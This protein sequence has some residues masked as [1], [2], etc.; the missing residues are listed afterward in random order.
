MTAKNLK[1]LAAF[2]IATLLLATGGA[3]T[4]ATGPAFPDLIQLPIGFGS[5]GIAVG[6]GHTFYVGSFTAPMVGQ[7]LVGDLRTGTYSEL[8][9]PTG[10]MA[11]G[12]KVDTRSNS[13][14]VAGGVSGLGKIYDARSGAEIAVYEFAA[15]GETIIND[16]VV[17]QKAAYFTDSFRP[18]LGRVSLGPHGEPE[19][20]DLIPLP[21]NFGI[22]GDC[23]FGLPPRS[24]GITA[25]ANGKYLVLV[26][27]SE[28]QLYLIDT[29]TFATVPIAVSGGDD[30]GGGPACGGDGLLLH[31]RTLYVVQ[32]PLDRVAV[33]ELAPDYLSGTVSHYITE[34]FASNAATKFPTTIAEFGNALYAV[35]Y[36]DIAP[37]PDYVVRLEK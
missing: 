28:G 37:T 33:I 6:R 36:G 11:V 4:A 10:T 35:T 23:V 15:P 20:S 7:I 22:S 17:T 8:V 27:M 2:V 26:H 13:L 16:V 1:V 18:F 5:E 9:P 14:F 19:A 29:T 21:T 3:R 32:A 34:P 30:A 24:N 12:M 25:T 31:G